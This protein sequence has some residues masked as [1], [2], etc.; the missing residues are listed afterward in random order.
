MQQHVIKW[1]LVFLL[2]AVSTAHAQPE[3]R[4]IPSIEPQHV[5]DKLGGPTLVS[6]HLKNATPQQFYEELAKQTGPDI[7]WAYPYWKAQKPL[8]TLDVDQEPFWLVVHKFAL[9][10]GRGIAE[11]AS[12]LQDHLYASD[13]SYDIDGFYSSTEPFFLTLANITQ[14]QTRVSTVAYGHTK[15]SIGATQTLNLALFSDPKVNFFIEQGTS[16]VIQKAITDNGISL[17]DHEKGFTSY[18]GHVHTWLV[19]IPFD[20]PTL[21]GKTIK[22]L[23]GYFS[24]DVETAKKTWTIPDITKAQGATFGQIPPNLTDQDTISNFI[25]KYKVNKVTFEEKPPRFVVQLYATHSIFPFFNG[26]S[27]W[28]P[29][30]SDV[31]VWGIDG[32]ERHISNPDNTSN[33]DL[34]NDPNHILEQEQ[35]DIDLAVNSETPGEYPKKMVWQ[36]PTEFRSVKVPFEFHDI[37]LP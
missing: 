19:S 37:P 26:I 34:S 25:A 12:M 2:C 32:K 28:S 27:S 21:S 1:V 18:S 24:V 8:V 7:L 4:Q 11:Q 10:T 33:H 31:H 23:K 17:I 35:L 3:V 5:L 6:I 22:I 16:F 29:I 9:Q 30:F 14:H 13:E 15:T 36:V 20:K